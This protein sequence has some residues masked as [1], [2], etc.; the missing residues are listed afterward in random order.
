MLTRFLTY[1]NKVPDICQQNY[2]HMSATL[3]ATA[4]NR[5]ELIVGTDES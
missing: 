5:T 3:L 4:V 1:V 2:R